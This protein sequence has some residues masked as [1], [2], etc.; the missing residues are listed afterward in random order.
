MRPGLSPFYLVRGVM[1]ASA[2][3]LWLARRKPK[4]VREAASPAA[5]EEPDRL[6]EPD[7]AALERRL[8]ATAPAPLRAL[9]EEA[10]LLAR[11]G[12][13]VGVPNP[14]AGEPECWIEAFEPLTGEASLWSADGAE[15]AIARSAAGGLYLVDPR[16][17][18][19]PVLYVRPDIGRPEPI[20]ATLT[21]FLEA[22]R[23]AAAH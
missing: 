12:L 3:L 5:T 21:Q 9:Y 1:I 2:G 19:P 4:A 14:V 8:G 10:E 23:R 7:F 20:G 15:L 6:V 17:A 11:R 18:D 13:R 22:A 16:A